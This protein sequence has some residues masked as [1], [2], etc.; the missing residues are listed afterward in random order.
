MT[1]LPQPAVY[2]GIDVSK[3]KL[4][5]AID[6]QADVATFSN[7]AA[8]VAQLI[9]RIRPMH[10]TL[11][12]FEA[13]GGYERAVLNAA[14]DAQLPAARVQP[15][16]VRHFAKAQGLLAKSDGIDARLLAL[17]ARCLQPA[18]FEKRSKKQAEL[19][20]LLVLRRQLIDTRTAH[21]NQMQLA[22]SS[23]ARRTLAQLARKVHDQVKKVD[24]RIERLIDSDDNL[25]GRCDLLMSVPGIGKTTAAT[26]AAQ[27]P[28]LGKADRRQICAL[29]GL[30]PFDR[31]SGHWSGKRSIFGGRGAVRS[32]LY[33]ATITAIRCNPVISDFARR[34]QNAGKLPKVVITACMRKLLTILNAMARDGQIWSPSC[35]LQTT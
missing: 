21:T 1:P 29:V 12:V 19:D 35:Q 8:G 7:D 2:I 15:S 9:E 33:M 4:D 32:V 24:K 26:L 22:D 25:S 5:L 30:A 28:E 14:L 11:I 34:L 18:I 10:P 20:A 27:L 3:D 6:G 13:T 31:D 16:R 23:F 17:Y